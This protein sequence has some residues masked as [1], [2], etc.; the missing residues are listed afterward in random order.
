MKLRKY[1]LQYKIQQI[2]TKYQYI[3]VFH[4][5][6][7]FSA[8][9]WQRLKNKLYLIFRSSA[10]PDNV[11][12]GNTFI[13]GSS[14]G[15]AKTTRSLELGFSGSKYKPR[16]AAG[17]LFSTNVAE[18]AWR[19]P[20][21]RLA[22]AEPGLDSTQDTLSASLRHS[23]PHTYGKVDVTQLSRASLTP[24]ER[25]T[26]KHCLSQPKVSS[27]AREALE[28][29]HYAQE[30][31]REAS[32]P[33]MVNDALDPQPQIPTYAKLTNIAGPF[34]IVYSSIKTQD[35]ADIN[36]SW[37]K[38][39]NKIGHCEQNE[40]LVLLYA[41]LNLTLVNHIDMKHAMTLE[42]TAVLE[43]FLRAMYSPAQ[44]LYLC[45]NE[46]REDVIQYGV[47]FCRKHAT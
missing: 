15:R 24:F 35:A 12:Q 31:K 13:L 46:G 36:N 1:I 2:D 42:K 39:L 18:K 9:Q 44:Y 17:S 30:E 22:M 4:S 29:K 14:Q 7:G 23:T 3:C 40:N 28:E 47:Q 43:P 26:A 33:L 45:L 37:F 11:V 10:S 5:S 41:K 27:L 25:R 21:S 38:L 34:C 19:P 6:R 16:R 32:L 20:F 8:A